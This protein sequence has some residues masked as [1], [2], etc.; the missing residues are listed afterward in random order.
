MFLAVGE[1]VTG[2]STTRRATKPK[3]TG[4]NLESVDLFL[5][6]RS[7]ETLRK[8]RERL[9]SFAAEPFG[10]RE[11]RQTGILCHTIFL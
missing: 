6:R 2:G 10:G 4:R 5:G 8:P 9:V 1:L 7:C 3:D 11:E